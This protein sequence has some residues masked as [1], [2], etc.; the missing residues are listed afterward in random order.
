VL[1]EETCLWEA[2]VAMPINDKVYMWNEETLNWEEIV[3]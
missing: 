3:E 1:N 2:P